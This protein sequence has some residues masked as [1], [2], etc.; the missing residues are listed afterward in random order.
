MTN[1]Q[2]NDTMKAPRFRLQERQKVLPRLQSERRKLA[3][4]LPRSPI[5]PLGQALIL[6]AV[7]FAPGI[8]NS[9]ACLPLQHICRGVEFAC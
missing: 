3:A 6:K 9:K 1:D 8:H 2:S 4:E 5:G 7:Q